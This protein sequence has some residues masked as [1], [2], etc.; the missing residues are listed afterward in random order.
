MGAMLMG[1]LAFIRLCVSDRPDMVQARKDLEGYYHHE[2][3]QPFMA[4]YN[5]E[6]QPVTI[7][8]KMFGSKFWLTLLIAIACTITFL[9]LAAPASFWR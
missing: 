9:L 7:K 8:H 6:P 2:M 3:E 4:G 5:G 1:W